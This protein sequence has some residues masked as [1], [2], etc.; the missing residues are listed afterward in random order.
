MHCVMYYLASCGYQALKIWL[1]ISFVKLEHASNVKYTP[2]FKNLAQG[3]KSK[4]TLF[5]NYVLDLLR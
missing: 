5:L 3:R 1:Y 4:V 2:D